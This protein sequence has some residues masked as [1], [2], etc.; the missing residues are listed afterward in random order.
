MS[1]SNVTLSTFLP[2]DTSSRVHITNTTIY[3]MQQ[4]SRNAREIK[5]VASARNLYVKCP[6]CFV[7]IFITRKYSDRTFL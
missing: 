5:V 2:R 1:K 3:H 4:T 6:A 7:H